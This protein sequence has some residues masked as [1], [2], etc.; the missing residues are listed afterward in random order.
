MCKVS[1]LAKSLEPNGVL[2]DEIEERKQLWWL[3]LQ[4]CTLYHIWVSEVKK[5]ETPFTETILSLV[6][7]L[8]IVFLVKTIWHTL[9]TF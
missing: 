2:P 3:L 5:V 8:S 7:D 6:E 1:T 4:Q 9:E